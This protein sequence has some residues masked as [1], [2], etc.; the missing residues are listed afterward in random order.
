MKKWLALSNQKLRTFWSHEVRYIFFSHNGCECCVNFTVVVGTSDMITNIKIRNG[1]ME[2]F[3]NIW[4]IYIR[5]FV[6]TSTIYTIKNR[7]KFLPEIY[8]KRVNFKLFKKNNWYIWISLKYYTFF[9]EYLISMIK[10][11]IKGIE[12]II[13]NLYMILLS[14]G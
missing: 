2:V 5:T 6:V 1:K 13:I 8:F 3:I 10:I 12:L 11:L 4:W 7:F 14:D 9:H